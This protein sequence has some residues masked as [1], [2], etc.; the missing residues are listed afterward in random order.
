MI[1]PKISVI[2]VT[3]NSI[4]SIERSIKSINYQTYKHIEKVWVDG[5]SKDGTF[6]YLKQHQDINTIL[7]SEKDNGIFEAINKGINLCSG[8]IICILHSDDKFF[9]NE[10]LINVSK[11]FEKNDVNVVF[12]NLI[13][14]NEKRKKIRNWIAED[15]L[16]KNKIL[17]S[18]HFK[19]KIIDGWMAPHPT[20]FLKKSLQ[21]E[22]G[23]YDTKY[24][25]SSDYDFI[26]R[27][28][29]SD[30]T[31][32]FYFNNTLIEMKI[33]GKSNKNLFNILNKMKEDY[34]IINKNKLNGFMTLLKKNFSKLNQFWS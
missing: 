34:L 14:V 33:G 19:K 26:I 10:V 20:I 7:T 5:L 11:I 4:N 8:E 16:F 27:L 25:I 24:S 31:K 29:S 18:N 28:F 21:N 13:Y 23:L 3:Y 30:K 22:I 1:N 15:N 6:E 17:R 2:T 12:G 32:A 9:S